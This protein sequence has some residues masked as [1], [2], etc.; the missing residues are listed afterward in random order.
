MCHGGLTSAYSNLQ[1]RAEQLTEILAIQ[2]RQ[3]EK[4]AA[5]AAGRPPSPVP[6]AAL[7]SGLFS[8]KVGSLSS[9]SF[10]LDVRL[11]LC[12]L[13]SGAHS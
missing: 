12:L 5:R 2:Q 3:V 1:S 4:A 10:L 11:A 8:W 13:V 9:A 7:A 6:L